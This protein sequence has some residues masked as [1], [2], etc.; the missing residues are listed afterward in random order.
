[1]AEIKGATMTKHRI[2]LIYFHGCPN[3]T[4]ARENLRAAG[5]ALGSRLTWSEWDLMAESTPD[6][7]RAHGSPTVLIDGE[8]IT[9][10]GHHAVA[11]ACRAD[12]PPSVQEITTRLS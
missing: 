2:D 1:M 3:V 12:G 9:G 10:T 5:E 8:D 7:Y 4:Q 11:L 6:E